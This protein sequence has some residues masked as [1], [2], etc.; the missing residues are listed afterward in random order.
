MD[1]YQCYYRHYYI[2]R[3]SCITKVSRKKERICAYVRTCARA[4]VCVN[5]Y[6][7]M[8]G[9]KRKICRE[10]QRMLLQEFVD[11]EQKIVY[12]NATA[13]SP[14]PL[15]PVSSVFV[16]NNNILCNV[17]RNQSCNRAEVSSRTTKGR[18]RYDQCIFTCTILY[19][20]IYRYIYLYICN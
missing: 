8:R 12:S 13:A 10:G 16:F 14:P 2:M 9:S 7:K 17:H 11:G 3:I 5:V 1:S 6:K 4:R 18:R 15:A 20:Y 19:K